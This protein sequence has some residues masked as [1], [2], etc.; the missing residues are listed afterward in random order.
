M[1]PKPSERK[2]VLLAPPRSSKSLPLTR[3]GHIRHEMAK[4]YREARNSRIDLGDATKLVFILQALGRIIE[5]SELE[6]RIEKLEQAQ[7]A[8]NVKSRF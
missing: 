2:M 7:E 6:A 3:M 8:N 5:G 4:V 1:P